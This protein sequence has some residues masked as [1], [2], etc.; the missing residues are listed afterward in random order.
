MLPEVVSHLLGD[1]HGETG[2]AS[3]TDTRQ[4]QHSD[5]RV[6]QVRPSG[7]Q[8]GFAADERSGRKWK[9][10]TGCW[11]HVAEERHACSFAKSERRREPADRIGMGSTPRA[12]KPARSASSDWVSRAPIRRR[13][14]TSPNLPASLATVTRECLGGQCRPPTETNRVCDACASCVAR[15]RAG[16]SR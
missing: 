15:A 9:L 3:P 1:F 8:L 14:S 11:P 13:R 2:L 5:V 16:K 6:E 7:A 10:C 4:G 12:L